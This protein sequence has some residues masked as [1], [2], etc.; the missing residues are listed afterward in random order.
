MPFVLVATVLAAFV[1][2][3]GGVGLVALARS[4]GAIHRG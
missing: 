2:A 3:S 1:P 4:W